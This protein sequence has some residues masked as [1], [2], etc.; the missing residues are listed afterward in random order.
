MRKFSKK[1]VLYFLFAYIVL[2][3][4]WWEV[5]LVKIHHQNFEKEKQIQALKLTDV[6]TFK[7]AEE[8]LNKEQI[9]KVIMITGEGTVF[10]I[11]ILFGF[12]RLLKA[13]EREM[14]I[15]ERQTNFLLSLP[16]EI[17]TPLSVIQLNL[18]T[19]LYN[20]NVT[21]EQKINI[22]EK[23]LE[24]LK[25][26]NVLIDHLLHTNKISKGKYILQKEKFNLS[27]KIKLWMVPYL[28]QKPVI[29]QLADDLYVEGDVQLIQL[30]AQNLLSNA[31]KFSEKEISLKL[32]SE[33]NKVYL[34]VCNDGEWINENEKDRIFELFYRR[35]M[36][37]EKGI[38]GTGLGLYLVKQIVDLHQIQIRVF[39]KNNMNV[40][41]VVF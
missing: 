28:E 12:Y 4:L 9:L 23:A 6:N 11:L 10:L 22:T 14:I 20:K 31:I 36:D 3:F 26:L 41:Q 39:I 24:E 33:K 25:R 17:K 29:L 18:Q 32:Y 8:Q 13:Y 7:K 27:E 2:Q 40:F 15:S 34:E 30:M 35:P 1:Q 16:H 38:K 19:I 5:L 21:D 37:E